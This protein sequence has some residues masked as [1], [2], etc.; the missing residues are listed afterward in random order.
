MTRNSSTDSPILGLQP[1][2]IIRIYAIKL[3]ISGDRG[4]YCVGIES[5]F[6][7]LRVYQTMLQY[8]SSHF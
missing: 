1:K 2:T 7:Q 5:L 6:E 4:L 3:Q 8:S